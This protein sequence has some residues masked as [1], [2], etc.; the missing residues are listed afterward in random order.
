M[1]ALNLALISC[2]FRLLKYSLLS[3][4]YGFLSSLSG[5]AL[6]IGISAKLIIFCVSDNP[7]F[8]HRLSDL[9]VYL[10]ILYLDVPLC[11]LAHFNIFVKM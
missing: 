2:S 11:D 5:V 3:N 6:M 10:F 7:Q 1:V 9:T 8:H 4:L